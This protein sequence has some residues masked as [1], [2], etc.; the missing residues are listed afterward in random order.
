MRRRIQG[1]GLNQRM[2][3]NKEVGWEHQ[4]RKVS[5]LDRSIQTARRDQ[6][7]GIDLRV[8]T[9]EGTVDHRSIRQWFTLGPWMDWTACFD[10]GSWLWFRDGL[11]CCLWLADCERGTAGQEHPP[12]IIHQSL[13][14]EERH[15]TYVHT[16]NYY[17][18]VGSSV[19]IVVST[20][21][22]KEDIRTLLS[23]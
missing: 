1:T 19:T 2:R 16:S 5:G 10:S 3:K 17:M 12:Q 18:S 15:S 9:C 22:E 4:R 14:L 21:K 6:W 13:L 8:G 20:H 23:S 11:D 7:K